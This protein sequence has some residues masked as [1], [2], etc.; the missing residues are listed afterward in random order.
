[1]KNMIDSEIVQNFTDILAKHGIN[2]LPIMKGA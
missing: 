1:M 2:I